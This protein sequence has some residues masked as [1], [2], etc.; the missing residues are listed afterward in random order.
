MNLLYAV[1]WDSKNPKSTWSGTG[2]SLYKAL[3]EKI[4]VD[5]VD[6]TPS[7]FEKLITSWAQI[8]AKNGLPYREK[9]IYN[10]HLLKIQERNLNKKINN[11][12][13]PLLSIARSFSRDY[14]NQ[15]VYMDLSPS[16]MIEIHKNKPEL[17]K[18]LPFNM[19]SSQGMIWQRNFQQSAYK[20]CKAVFTMSEWVRDILIKEDGLDP[21]SVFAVGGGI[22]LDVSKIKACEKYNNKILFVGRDF[23]RKGGDLVVKAFQMLKKEMPEAELYVAGPVKKPVEIDEAP[24]GIHF[25]GYLSFDKVADYFNMCDIFCMP[26]RFEAYGLVYIEALVYG[27]P[28]I[29]NNDFAMKEIIHHGENG[30][31]ISNENINDIK[32]KMK[33]LLSNK[34]I[35]DNVHNSRDK[36]IKEYSWKNVADKMLSII[37][38]NENAD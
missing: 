13:A 14:S 19:T 37:R 6:T 10:E 20:N 33:D 30:Y 36:Y 8:R 18:Y 5:L 4:S 31:L 27:L 2:Y 24:D 25:L 17:A 15:Y 29:V 7:N 28:C 23:Y 35:K 26:S 3:S 38:Q 9:N 16:A 1:M 22:N 11:E 12:K 32:E 34:K 21:T